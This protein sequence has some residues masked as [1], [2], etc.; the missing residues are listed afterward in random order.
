MKLFKCKISAQTLGECSESD[1]E[2]AR[3][4]PGTSKEEPRR[5]AWCNHSARL[6]VFDSRWSHSVG[7]IIF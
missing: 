2:L 1:V 5:S 7:G 4:I 6:G 3:I